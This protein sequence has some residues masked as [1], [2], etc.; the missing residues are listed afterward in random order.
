[1]SVDARRSAGHTTP[2]E[3]L[4]TSFDAVWAYLVRTALLVVHDPEAAQDIAADVVVRV[5]A[6]CNTWR[7]GIASPHTYLAA[8]VRNTAFDHIALRDNRGE[9]HAELSEQMASDSAGAESALL[10]LER[11]LEAAALLTEIKLVVAGL[12]DEQRTAVGKTGN[13][14]RPPSAIEA[15]KIAIRD[16]LGVEKC[17]RI[18]Q[19][20]SEG[21]FRE[22]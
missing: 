10:A 11:R 1:M 22:E 19:L 17:A 12:P 6:K 13:R 8:A 14:G 2:A 9:S 7:P 21:Y 20:Y 4:T 15:A 5:L 18:L 3:L 16:T